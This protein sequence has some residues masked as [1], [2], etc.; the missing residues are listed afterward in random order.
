MKILAF[1]IFLNSRM[2]STNRCSK[3]SSIG[4]WRKGN[5]PIYIS[6]CFS[7][8]ISSSV[9]NLILT[10]QIRRIVH[11]IY[12]FAQYVVLYIFVVSSHHFQLSE[13]ESHF[14]KCMRCDQALVYLYYY[15]GVTK[16]TRPNS[17][18]FQK[19]KMLTL[20]WAAS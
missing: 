16:Q 5:M 9:A 15:I 1:Y 19:E 11:G 10:F 20:K 2:H 8:F 4:K 12:K 17:Y 3:S 7:Q 18:E 6:K 13:L 14:T